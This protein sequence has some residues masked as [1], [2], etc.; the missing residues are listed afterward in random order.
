MPTCF[1]IQPFDKG[2]FDKRYEDVFAPAIKSAGLEPYRVDRDP[3]V[4]VPIEDIQRGIE[5]AS[6][7][8]ADITT[9]NPNVWFELG[10][11]IAAQKDVIMVC[12]EERITKYPFDVQHRTITKYSTESS[13]DFDSLRT[14][15]DS[16]IKATLHR[17]E[18]LGQVAEMQSVA[19]VEGLDQHLIAA[20]IIIAEGS[21]DPVDGVSANLIKQ[22]M[23]NAGFTSIAAHLGIKELAKIGMLESFEAV[24]QYDGSRYTCYRVADAGISWLMANQDKLK[25]RQEHAPEPDYM[26]AGGLPPNDDIPF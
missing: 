23:E 5:S 15:I 10:F 25:L 20:L 4:S 9:D 14:T 7:C 22:S 16:R 11:A 8:L 18:K 21:I 17:R 12:S 1:V 26:P 13:R 19:K 24:E 3:G 6:I 2:K